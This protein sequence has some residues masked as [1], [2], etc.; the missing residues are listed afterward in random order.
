MTT[1]NLRATEK[2]YYG[3][4]IILEGQA[5]EWTAPEWTLSGKDK[6][7]L[8]EAIPPWA[9]V[10]GNMPVPTAS[11]ESD[12]SDD[13]REA[14]IIEVV[15]NL[16]QSDDDHWTESGEPAVLAVKEIC[17]FSVSRADIKAL[18]PGVERQE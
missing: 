6:C 2:G 11:I 7:T 9:E 12:L 16:D 5:F 3:D 14:K 4:D 8:E 1:L 13:K 10:V 17:G 15:Q 18:C